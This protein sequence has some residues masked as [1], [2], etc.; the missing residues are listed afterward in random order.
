MRL[1][2]VACTVVVLAFAG[3]FVVT[4]VTHCG[5]LT[6]VDLF[7]S[8]AL[9]DRYIANFVESSLVTALNDTVGVVEDLFTDFVGVAPEEILHEVHEMSN[10]VDLPSKGWIKGQKT[11]ECRRIV[12]MC[13]LEMFGWPGFQQIFR[14]TR[15]GLWSKR[16]VKRCL[17]SDPCCPSC[18][19]GYE[20]FC[21]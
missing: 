6:L 18:T 3:F 14:D 9:R 7:C 12:E 5:S 19:A 21:N 1:I 20:P 13:G 10:C 4:H 15:L 11:D 2:F 16:H 17:M 8:S